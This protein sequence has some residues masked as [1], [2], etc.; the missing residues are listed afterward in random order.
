M[1]AVRYKK[2]ILVT[3]VISMDEK[4]LAE[5]KRIFDLALDVEPDQRAT[6][7]ASLCGDDQDL[8]NE[9]LNLIKSDM[10]HEMQPPAA[11]T[12]EPQKPYV[13][14]SR[15]EVKLKIAEGGFGVVLLA[16]DLQ[17]HG[18]SVV[19]KL[20][21]PHLLID[22]WVRSKFRSEIE[23]LARIHHPGVVSV[24]DQGETAEG[25]PFMVME[26]VD[27]DPLTDRIGPGGMDLRETAEI[28]RQ[29]GVALSAA[30]AQN[31]WH[32]DLKP[33]NILVHGSKG[34]LA[35]KLIDFGIA[36]ITAQPAGTATKVVGS[37]PY[38]APE[39]LKG[40]PN[41]QTDIYALGVVAYHMLTGRIPFVATSA[42]ALHELQREGKFEKPSV[43]RPELAPEVSTLIAKAMAYSH[44]DRF[45]SAL[46]FTYSLAEALLG[47]TSTKRFDVRKE[48]P[49]SGQLIPKLCDRRSQEDDFKNFFMSPTRSQSRFVFI[50]GDE[51]ACHESLVERLLYQVE[52][53]SSKDHRPD[54][55]MFRV[56]KIPWQYEGPVDVRRQRLLF[57]LVEQLTAASRPDQD[58]S[59]EALMTLL[60]K[61]QARFLVLQHEV[62]VTRWDQQSAQLIDSYV[63]FL[64]EVTAKTGSAQV[65]VFL[66]IVFP[67]KPRKRSFIEGIRL[68]RL[69]TNVDRAMQRLRSRAGSGPT[70]VL[71][72][73]STITQEDVMEWL[74]LHDI[75]DSED[76]RIR[77][78]EW[79]FS[80]SQGTLRMADVESRLKELH[81]NHLAEQ[82]I[83]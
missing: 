59:A 48:P 26:Y 44:E 28:L 53:I 29:T 80:T 33:D 32:R 25:H 58:F 64:S 67:G 9:V 65:L 83:V 63:D 51:G 27:A 70:L 3:C 37:M 17:L 39:Q 38:M 68:W 11:H 61:L 72:N 2:S 19:V 46:E 41:A 45:A 24:I 13:I 43:L 7:L 31:V 8:R 14:S 30:H 16:R 34:G 57:A 74:N 60:S 6:L 22:P 62:H 47:L 81:R 12:F 75:F 36:S 71:N 1:E 15:Y 79:V 55:A 20:P 35:V 52:T 73:L 4:R 18:R 78:S 40:H 76:K 54:Q 56:K 42:I 23:A 77:A 82:G 66:N 5:I 49:K 21:H 69:R 50:P 10:T